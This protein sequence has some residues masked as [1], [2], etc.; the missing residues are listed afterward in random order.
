MATPTT[1]PLVL[2]ADPLS[3]KRVRDAI[4]YAKRGYTVADIARAIDGHIVGEMVH[5]GYFL[6]P[7]SPNKRVSLTPAAIQASKE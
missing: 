1:T 2:P 7:S 5:L 3:D 6:A 4:F